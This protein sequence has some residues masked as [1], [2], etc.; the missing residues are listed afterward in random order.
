MTVTVRPDQEAEWW[1]TSDVAAYLGVKVSTVSN[2]RKRGQ[3][4]EPDM[5][6]GR[7]HMWRPDRVRA[8]HKSRPRP[9]VGGRPSPGGLEPS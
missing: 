3:M 9:G 7:T 5:T 1:T 8:W 6:I 2:Y 4:P